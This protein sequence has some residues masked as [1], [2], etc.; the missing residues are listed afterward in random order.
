MGVDRDFAARGSEWKSHAKR[1]W[2]FVWL[3]DFV[4]N[5][6][7]FTELDHLFGSLRIGE[8]GLIHVDSF[9]VF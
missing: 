7:F 2:S 3:E 8:L 9:Y 6:V 1:R 5:F 4:F